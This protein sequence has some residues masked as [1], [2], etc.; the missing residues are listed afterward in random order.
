MATSDHRAHIAPADGG[1][2]LVV[3]DFD[4]TITLDDCMDVVMALHVPSWPELSAAVQRGRLTQVAA[5]ERATRRLRSPR[6]AVLADF[7]AAAELRPGFK[8]FLTELLEGGA[9]AEVISAGFRAGIEAVW[10]R[11]GLPSIP[12]RAAALDAGETGGLEMVL[13]ERFGDCP[14]C[15]PGHCKAAVV[16]ALR[17]PGDVVVAFGDG[18][19]D[20]CMARAADRVFARAALARLC[21]REG[22]PW[23]PF[24]RFDGAVSTLRTG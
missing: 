16:S 8:E 9:R 4:G 22:V 3:M 18:V 10:R 24:E 2:L 17:G 23:T 19:R 15:G 5:F 20:L 1:R 6:P 13:D 11:E 12:V 21:E 14:V 7:V